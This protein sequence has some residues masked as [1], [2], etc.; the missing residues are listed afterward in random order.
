M[1]LG[2]IGVS[3]TMSEH[4]PAEPSAQQSAQD[5]AAESAP[6]AA[7]VARLAV[8]I[9]RA[10]VRIIQDRTFELRNLALDAVL[11]LTTDIQAA[12]RADSGSRRVAHARDFQRKSQ[13]LTDFIEAEY[14][15]G[16]HADQET[17]RVLALAI[18][19]A[20]RGQIALMS[21][22]AARP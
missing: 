6:K 5:S 11:K 1:L 12:V 16:F 21:G 20:R 18:D 13:F 15:M 4:L 22:P 2:G 17:A 19:Y 10:R 3:A 8:A 9:G 7:A 14:S